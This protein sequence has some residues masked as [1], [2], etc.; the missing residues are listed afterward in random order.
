MRLGKL[1]YL[2][3][4]RGVEEH[5]E[6]GRRRA[7]DGHRH[8][9]G[10]IAQ[11]EA[12]VQHLHVVER[13]DRHARVADLAVDVG[14]LVGV[15]AVQR[16]RVERGRQA[17]RGQVLRQQVE[18]P[19][20]AEGAA[21]AGEHARRILVLALEVEHPG[22]ERKLAR[23]VLAQA[24][25]QQLAVVLEFGQRD[26]GNPGARQRRA[27]ERGA[28][29]LAADFHDVLVAGIGLQRLGPGIKQRLRIRIE[30]S[31]REQGL[32]FRQ[33]LSE[34]R[35]GRRELLPLARD[36]RLLRGKLV[37]RPY[38]FRYLG[39]IALALGRNDDVHVR[40]DLG[41][42]P[43]QAAG[44]ELQPLLGKPGGDG[45]V[46]GGHAVVI[47]ARGDGAE[48]R[49]LLGARAEGLAVALDLL[50]HVAQRV[51]RALAVE[52]VDRHEI[53]EVEHVDL[54]ELARGAELRRHHVK[55]NVGVR[56]DGR[57]ALADAGRLDDDQL[58]PRCLARGD[59]VAERSRQRAPRL[60]R[61]KRAHEDPRLVDRIHADAVAQQGAAGFPARRVDRQHRDAQSVALIEAETAHQ[62]V[63]QRRF[64]CA[65]RAGDAKNGYP[66]F[67]FMK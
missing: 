28:D 10:R 29:F 66:C 13:R 57:I 44:L 36:S 52:L 9:G 24:P 11:V 63:G 14:P 3:V 58:E 48:H 54:L 20:G 43:R 45:V 19:V 65:P 4:D 41:I 18:A 55:R 64:S 35:P 30:R 1:L 61:G 25:A 7:I 50:A 67:L 49:H 26:L 40:R 51:L 5:R 21:F 22:G 31:L 17:L 2:L 60:A 38:R 27:A 8:R 47:K 6:E 16:H 34:H 12:G 33:L 23:Q 39:E 56:H 42:E 59:G 53:G 62:L 32:Y 37:I 46:Q 15:E